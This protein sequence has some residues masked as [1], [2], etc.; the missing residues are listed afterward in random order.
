MCNGHG[1]DAWHYPIGF[2]YDESNMIIARE[3]RRIKTEASL[4]KGAIAAIFS[5][6]ASRDFNNNLK[7]L[8]TD[9]EPRNQHEAPPE[10]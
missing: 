4:L 8:P 2:V 3:N 5:N 7:S 1:E 6:A 9:V 10:E